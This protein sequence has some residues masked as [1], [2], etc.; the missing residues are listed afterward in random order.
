[1]EWNSGESGIIRNR[2]DNAEKE[3]YDD[4][5]QTKCSRNNFG[6]CRNIKKNRETR[7]GIS[8]KWMH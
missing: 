3:E 7:A 1:M 2:A 6:N 8:A 4:K 5:M